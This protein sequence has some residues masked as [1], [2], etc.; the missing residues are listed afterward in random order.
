MPAGVG[1]SGDESSDPGLGHQNATRFP[2]G[3]E[4]SDLLDFDCE[5]RR[6]DGG[7]WD[8]LEGDIFGELHLDLF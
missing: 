1:S 4:S 7:L 6:D 8:D 3:D 2:R 5:V